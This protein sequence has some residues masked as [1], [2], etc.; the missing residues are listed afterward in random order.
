MV[1]QILDQFGRPFQT[2]KT[3]E[4]RPL[5]VAPIIESTREYVTSGLKPNTLA[6][7]FKEADAGNIARQ[8][9]LFAQIE[10]KD[11][12]ILG[13]K[14]KRQNV[15]V[16]TE[17]QLTPASDDARDVKV[18]EFVEGFINNLTDLS[19]IFI[20]L[21]DSVGKG[22]SS[23]EI[24]WD[25]SEGQ[26]LPMG[27]DFIDQRRFIFKDSKGVVQRT[28]LLITDENKEGIEIQPWKIIFHS[29]GGKSGHPT[30]SG[31]YRVCAWMYLFKN[32]SIKDWVTFCEVY[33]MPLRLGKYNTGA[34]QAEKDALIAAI[35]SLG[36]DAAGIISEE[37]EIEFIETVKGA[38]SGQIY[39]DL[40]DF[41]NKEV[42]KA[43][44]GQT[45]SAEIGEQGS[46]AA[47]KTH[48]EV[49]KDLWQADSRAVAA[50][51]RS[52]VI[53]PIVGFNFGWDTPIPYYAPVWKEEEDLN[54]KAEWVG[55]L[56]DRGLPIPVSWV[57]K[58]FNIP[59]PEKGEPILEV[60]Q[61]TI[62]AKNRI[63]AKDDG[64]DDIVNMFSNQLG[65]DAAG[66]F[67]GI[68]Q[69]VIKL[70]EKAKT[71][72]EFKD[73]LFSLYSDMDAS[74]L[75]IIMQRALAAAELLGRYEV[76]KNV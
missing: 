34:S 69:P 20:S 37:T 50:T 48:N 16:D 72:E 26:A 64:T 31:I 2:K 8:A 18:A 65:E 10:E 60:K 35:S 9:E 4:K 70:L 46:Y 36:S 33:G 45:L 58:E 63:I 61:Q 1:M 28:P 67:D 11:G 13:E 51:W 23:L 38:V 5:A 75:G 40:A 52:H 39:K 68:M 14:G 32:Y 17:F 7:I 30:R 54:K 66:I 27:F 73:G 22:F 43:I 42:S 49:R 56:A 71:L 47:S 6:S 21:Q 53:K 76:K 57:S 15:I 74:Q 12:H 19:D 62:P 41:S 24:G 55:T 59:A 25:I 3:P 44:L 29:Y